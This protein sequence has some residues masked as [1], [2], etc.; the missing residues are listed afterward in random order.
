MEKET[1]YA[2]VAQALAR[3]N[4]EIEKNYG[5]YRSE[6]ARYSVDSMPI[7]V[8]YIATVGRVEFFKR[9]QE[10]VFIQT[11][12][13]PDGQYGQQWESVHES[14]YSIRDEFFKVKTV[15][16]ALEFLQK[17]G[18]F[19]PFRPRLTWTEFQKWQIFARLVQE[20]D[21]LADAMR[22]NSWSG[23]CGEVL[24]ALTG[25]YPSSFFDGC[26]DAL[27]LHEQPKNDP[28]ADALRLEELHLDLR[29]ATNHEEFMNAH[30]R[31]TQELNA[32]YAQ[33]KYEQE[34]EQRRR[35]L[36]LWFIKPPVRIE[37]CP[38]DEEA[39]E[40]VMKFHV[41]S[42]TGL[43]IPMVED[44]PL[45][46]GGGLIEFLLPQSQLVPRL[47]I[48][49]RYALEAIAAAI[50]AER[51]QGI[52]SRKCDWC[53]ELFL[54]GRHKD[55]RYCDAKRCKSNAQ[56][57]RYRATHPIKKQK[58]TREASKPTRLRKAS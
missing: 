36:W 4:A 55:K 45:M 15:G 9:G 20:H 23:D 48:Q 27:Y 40:K 34:D 5:I 53:G 24:K 8:K 44:S 18:E 14:T 50:Y 16:Q 39:A 12:T 29:N 46:R 56:K 2:Q 21:P 1:D 32:H 52:T 6:A 47:V 41:D 10:H 33:E 31:Q 19:S 13:L 54:I 37:W 28:A 17:T 7:V 26:E 25:I 22:S 57:Q 3:R 49:P 38:I 58:K 42:A 35:S 11:K 30:E 51:I 43:V